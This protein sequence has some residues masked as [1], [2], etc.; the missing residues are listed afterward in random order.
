MS[1]Y[2][3]C[4][5]LALS[6][7]WG[8]SFYF[9][10]VGLDYLSPYWLVCLRLVSGAGFLLIWLAVAS[11]RLPLSWAFW[12]AAVIMGLINN[13]LP[14]CLIAWGQQF[15]TGGMAAIINANT[16]F[17]G[18]IVAALFLRAEPLRLHRLTGVILGVFGVAVAIGWEAL[19]GFGGGAAAGQLA[20]LAATL[21]YA[22]AGVWGKRRLAHSAPIQGAAAMLVSSAL[23]SIPVAAVISGMPDLSLFTGPHLFDA[24]ILVTGIGLFGTALA[25]PLYF[26]ILERAGASNLLL[27]TI[28]VP[29]FALV[30]DAWLLGQ[31]VTA[32]DLAGFCLVAAGLLIMDGRCFKKFSAHH[33]TPP[34]IR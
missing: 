9:I 19:D 17:F 5:L 16:A 32:S 12:R 26:A 31:W 18:V 30:L 34:H 8:A 4:L 3:W 20:I 21:S 15:I 14:F 10:E 7:I 22:F 6:V 33:I 27:V 28:I 23:I 29:V 25:Y 24:L 13:L 2:V 1:F 11:I